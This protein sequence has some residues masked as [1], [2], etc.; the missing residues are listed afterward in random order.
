M[1]LKAFEDVHYIAQCFMS[2]FA[3]IKHLNVIVKI[4]FAILKTLIYFISHPLDQWRTIPA[5]ADAANIPTNIK[6]NIDF[7][8]LC[9]SKILQTFRN[10]S[11]TS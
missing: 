8:I 3:I 11:K 2:V 5:L 9:S 6:T 1:C 7:F 10:L 4:F